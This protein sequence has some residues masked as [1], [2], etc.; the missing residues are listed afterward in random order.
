MLRFKPLE[1]RLILV[2]NL[3]KFF[4]V[5]DLRHTV[6]YTIY[7][8]VVIEEVRGRERETEKGRQRQTHRQRNTQ[9]D[10]EI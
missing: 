4:I 2:F 7:A 10:T 3:G 6:Y 1:V 5:C 8:F 9:I